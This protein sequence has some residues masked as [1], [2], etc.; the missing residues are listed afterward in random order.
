MFIISD[1]TIILLNFNMLQL[2]HEATVANLLELIL[3]HRDTCEAAGDGIL[4]MMDYCFHKIAK[5]TTRYV[6]YHVT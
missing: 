5:L 6:S 2:Y 3:F 4:D 1:L